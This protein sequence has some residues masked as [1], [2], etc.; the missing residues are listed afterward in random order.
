LVTGTRG[1]AALAA[2]NA[3]LLD[4]HSTAAPV[5]GTY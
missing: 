5:T 2:A 4:L 3:S 1:K